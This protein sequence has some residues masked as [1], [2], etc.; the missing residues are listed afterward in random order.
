MWFFRLI[1]AI[2]T[3]VVCKSFSLSSW[4]L[5]LGQ[6]QYY[7][8]TDEN[9][10]NNN[11]SNHCKKIVEISA[12]VAWL[13]LVCN[14]QNTIAIAIAAK[15]DQK[16]HNT[17]VP[18]LLLTFWPFNATAIFNQ[19]ILFWSGMLAQCLKR[20][21]YYYKKKDNNNKFLIER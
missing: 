3:F 7:R 8:L 19:I 16:Q 15:K 20:E 17:K 10:N 21:N 6:L 14:F 4:A 1:I 11:E 13:N 18:L 5:L 12:I 9:N 2:R